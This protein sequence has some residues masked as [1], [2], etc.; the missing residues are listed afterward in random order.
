M[1]KPLAIAAIAE[2]AT[3][4]ALIFAPS[5]VARL[6]LGADLT[7]VGLAV[8]RVAGFSLVAMGV[9]CWPG[10]E[11]MRGKLCGMST[12]GLLVTLY[13][14]YLGLWTECSG[15]LLWPAIL[16][17]AVLTFLLIRALFAPR[18]RQ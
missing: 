9:A 13:L 4:G 12:Y 10:A 14:A 8:G 7:G 16:A 15:P 1:N 2:A 5:L 18:Q 6:L 3:G 11:A 17:H